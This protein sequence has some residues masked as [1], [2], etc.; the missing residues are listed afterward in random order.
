MTAPNLKRPTQEN[1]RSWNDDMVRRYNPEQY[2]LH[3][4]WVIRQIE[5]R[6]IRAVTRAF[7]PQQ[8][9]KVL[10]VGCGAGNI[11]ERV[12]VPYRVGIDLSGLMVQRTRQRLADRGLRIET[13]AA[14]AS[15]LPFPARVFDGAICTEVLEHVLEP[16]TVTREIRRV[17]KPGATVV[18]SVPN[19]HLIE[20]LKRMVFGMGL[21][22]LFQRG[23]YK[24][25]SRMTEE[26]HLHVFDLPAIRA[27]LEPDF[28][29]DAVTAIPFSW[30]P[31]RY[32]LRCTPR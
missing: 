23:A 31:I 30:L 26:W 11:L 17:V 5:K 32:V 15:R 2:H 21:G 24:V 16:G 9:E 28:H 6:R 1:F 14:D 8:H 27:I 13:L 18:I 3:A 7:R 29:I 22:R 4:V 10:E 20:R 25:P 19:E 12:D